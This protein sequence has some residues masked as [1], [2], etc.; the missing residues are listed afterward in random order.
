MRV[1]LAGNPNSGKT[2]LFNL[3]T[4]ST[5]H[6]GNWPG[7]TIDKKVGVYR[8]KSE[9]LKIDIIDLPGI[10]SL[11]PY[12]PE[13][14]ITRN[15]IID[16]KPD[17]IIN[18]VDATNLERN[19][20]LSTQLIE[21]GV[22][23]VIALNMIDVVEKRQGSI[24]V[25]AI[26]KKMGVPVVEISALKNKGIKDLMLKVNE[27]SQEGI[28]ERSLLE[29][30]KHF[31]LVLQV[32]A[33]LDEKKVGCSLFHA[34][35][36]LENDEVEMQVHQELKETLAIL[37][38]NHQDELFG[39]D[40]EAIIADARYKFISNN[41][42]KH[43]IKGSGSKNIKISD[44]IDKVLT[45]RIFGLP[46]FALVMLFVFHFTF[47]E[48]LFFI[49]AIWKGGIKVGDDLVGIPS[50]GFFL[51]T[52]VGDGVEGL[53]PGLMA[54]LSELAK[55]SLASQAPWVSSLVVDAL[56]GGV[57]AVLSFI[58]QIMLLYFFLS[59]LEDSGY[60]ARV[61]F[62]LDK[63]LRRFGITGKA[64]MP[65]IMC[66]GCAV[67][68]IFA[69]RTLENAKEKRLTIMLTPF[70]SC[71]AK[72][73]IWS[74]FA[75]I[76][77][78]KTTIPAPE[79]IVFA[80]YLIGIAV[81]I[82]AA[83]ILKRTIFK[84]ETPPFILELPEYRM[85]KFKN[86]M[87]FL[88]DKMKH[89][90]YKAATIIAAS[91]IVIWFLSN[92]NW[93]YK[94]VET[95][96]DSILADIGKGIRW[97][98]VPLGFAMNPTNAPAKGWMFVVA[99]FTGLLAKE[100]VVSTLGMFSSSISGEAS[101]ADAFDGEEA[102]GDAG[103]AFAILLGSLSAPALFS[104]M[105]FNLLTIP[106]LAAVAAARSELNNKRH[107]MA[108]LLFWFL[109]SYIISLYVYWVGTLKWLQ[110]VSLIIL[111]SFVVVGLVAFIGKRR[112]Q[113]RSSI[114]DME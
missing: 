109:T 14:I 77:L 75:I 55:N 99:A 67:P 108:A 16:E 29:G 50:L 71:G 51:Q 76:L 101:D 64:F 27:V 53:Y 87:V 93:E 2:T 19:L 69:T 13:E 103:S 48:D 49:K 7:V 65:L 102:A 86:T 110:I 30:S 91:T 72:L 57:G 6:V 38:S 22:P 80:M 63:L 26:S 95:I 41:L 11:S 82:I 15:Y 97:I 20:Y 24:D 40:F 114:V 37:R 3:L 58:P 43:V 112:S 10:Y 42:S 9:N 4:G 34:I 61:S 107:L 8:S 81:S 18:I 62:I 68:G 39:D 78:R 45:S 111:I 21:L 33:L 54:T 60:M 31:P 79:L 83:I 59:L 106:C 66:F 92:F 104:F 113:K 25:E 28:K 52:L 47:S 5:A 1:A 32:K 74:V 89:Y 46:I 56:I 84:G 70:F 96:N 88:W 94:M 100:V 73:P 105:V 17:A 36:L 44:K 98:F 35:K 12:T 23:L 85:P 90:V